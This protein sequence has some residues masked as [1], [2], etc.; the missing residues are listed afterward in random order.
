MS[1]NDSGAG[2][3]H[4]DA[5]THEPAPA[6]IRSHRVTGHS[7]GS[8][9]FVAQLR[10]RRAASWRCTPLADGRRDP[11]DPP[12]RNGRRPTLAEI[13]AWAAAIE[14]LAAH[15]HDVRWCLSDEVTAELAA[16]S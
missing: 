8:A 2:A 4:P 15:G 1:R 5:A 12:P 9:A 11:L 3:S 14:L 7:D 13:D 6:V 10:H 16:A